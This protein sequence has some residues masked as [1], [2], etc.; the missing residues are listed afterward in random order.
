MKQITVNLTSGN[1]L[2]EEDLVDFI[3]EKFS[4]AV[5]NQV[6]I[7]PIGYQSPEQEEM[8]E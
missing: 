7:K 5:V 6:L 2:D 1:D 8:V 4:S 3:Q